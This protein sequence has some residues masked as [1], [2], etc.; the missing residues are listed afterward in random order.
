MDGFKVKEK[1]GRVWSGTGER[2]GSEL[3][4]GIVGRGSWGGVCKWTGEPGE[5]GWRFIISHAV[6][7]PEIYISNFNTSKG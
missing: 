3:R 4:P 1:S 5:A 6:E 7:G 2:A